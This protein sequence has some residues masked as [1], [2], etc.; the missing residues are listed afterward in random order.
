LDVDLFGGFLQETWSKKAGPLSS[1]SPH[2]PI[3]S[4]WELPVLWR[5]LGLRVSQVCLYAAITGVGEAAVSRGD[6]PIEP[7]SSRLRGI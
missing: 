6:K 5:H 2:W 4:S 1:H 3:P 7:L